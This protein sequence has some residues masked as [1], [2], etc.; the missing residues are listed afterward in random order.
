MF[1]TTVMVMLMTPG[2]AL[3]RGMV[4]SKM[5]LAQQCIA[6]VQWQLFQFNGL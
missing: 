2:L 5:Y 6:I 1:V 3:L 4:R